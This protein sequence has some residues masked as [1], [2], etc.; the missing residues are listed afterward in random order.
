MT[1]SL[2]AN[3]KISDCRNPACSLSR[4][5]STSF[6]MRPLSRFNVPRGPIKITYLDNGKNATEE[7]PFIAYLTSDIAN[8]HELCPLK[9]SSIKINN[10]QSDTAR[11]NTASHSLTS[12]FESFLKNTSAP[13]YTP[14]QNKK[15]DTILSQNHF[16]DFIQPGYTF[17]HS[18]NSIDG[19][20]ASYG[21]CIYRAVFKD[22]KTMVLSIPSWNVVRKK[23]YKFM[24]FI[25]DSVVYSQKNGITK[26]VVAQLNNGGGKAALKDFFKEVLWPDLF[27]SEYV[28]QA[29]IT[30]V[31]RFLLRDIN[32]VLAGTEAVYPN[33]Y[34]QLDPIKT[35]PYDL[36]TFS[37]KGNLTGHTRTRNYTKRFLNIEQLSYNFWYPIS[38]IPKSLR[39]K[40]AFSPQ[41][42][43]F[44][45]DGFCGSACAYLTKWM[46]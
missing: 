1:V 39:A 44:V 41:N 27:P 35:L 2:W 42:I 24:S 15:V 28:S 33:T 13:L 5:L 21:E 43:V 30:E 46:K 6:S 40:S 18:A 38:K 37:G 19:E 17:E 7:I 45:T 31:S 20:Y 25:V 10:Q 8:T 32:K 11:V 22:L 12:P 14:V 26:L 9:S 4:T 16:D 29:P 36:K 34:K 3:M 23:W